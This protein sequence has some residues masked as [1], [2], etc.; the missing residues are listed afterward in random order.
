[1]ENQ[2]PFHV[3]LR[4]EREL[5]GWSQADIAQKVGSDVKTVGRWESGSSLPRPYYRQK[6]YEVFGKNA[7]DMGLLEQVPSSE[8]LKNEPA[9]GEK[10]TIACN[11]N[12]DHR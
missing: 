6:L 4:Y 9:L 2:Q 1:M 8:V 3:R 10:H 11:T 12:H 7:Q 5:R